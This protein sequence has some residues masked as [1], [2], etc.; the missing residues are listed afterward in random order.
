VLEGSTVSR[1][2]AY[3]ALRREASRTVTDGAGTRV[4]DVFEYGEA[5]TDPEDENLRGK[6]WRTWH[7][8]GR[9]E[10]TSYDF[11]GN[12]LSWTRRY[13]DRAGTSSDTADWTTTDDGN[14]ESDTDLWLTTAYT[15]DALNRVTSKTAPDGAVQ[16]FT[17]N[18]AGLFE[19]TTVDSV[20]FVSGVAYNA[21]GQREN[22][23]YGNGI[24]TEYTYEPETFRLATLES[25]RASD[26]KVLQDLTFTYDPVGN[27][28]EIVNAADDTVF[29]DNV[30]V[31]PDQ[32]FTYDAYYRLKTA[33]GREKV[34]RGQ[35][36]N[37]DP[38]A[39][40]LR[41]PYTAVALYEER[42]TYDA[43][44]NITEMRH[45]VN[46]ATD[47]VR[48]YTYEEDGSNDPVSNRLVDTTES[49]GT[50]EYQHDDRGNIVF[51]PHLYND[52]ATPDPSPNVEYDDRGQMVRAQIN[53]SD[54][55]LYYYDSAGQRVRKVV[56]TGAVVEDRRYVDGYE[57][58]RKTSS[59]TLTEERTTL[60][61]MDGEKRIA[62]VETKTVGTS[63]PL[64]RIRYQLGNHLGT[65]V[66]E[67]NADGDVISY[68]E[69][70]PYGSTAWWTND[71]DTEVSQKRYR[72]TGKEKDEETGL[73]YHGARYY[74][75]WLGRWTSADPSRLNDGASVYAYTRGRPVN[76]W[77]PT[78]MEGVDPEEDADEGEGDG[79]VRGTGWTAPTDDSIRPVSFTEL[80]LAPVTVAVTPLVEK[81]AETHPLFAEAMRLVGESGIMESEAVLV[82]ED[83]PLVKA[84]TAT[85]KVGAQAAVRAAEAGSARLALQE[86]GTGIDATI[87]RAAKEGVA[88]M[89]V[90]TDEGRLAFRFGK[91][92]ERFFRALA[93]VG[94]RAQ[95]RVKT[96]LGARY[97]DFLEPT[98]T[99]T[100]AHEVK[101]G[102]VKLSKVADQIA[103]DKEILS[104]GAGSLRVESC[105]WH[106]FANEAGAIGAEEAVFKALD[107]AGIKYIIHAE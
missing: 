68:E 22:I 93:D 54:Y 82:A 62:M 74:A 6:P 83:V 37:G 81:W 18:E 19:T 65:S 1:V 106:F 28:R 32:A 44:G 60:H 70:H 107:E 97:I 25:T 85:A 96:A 55:A 92:A 98:A 4:T 40:T 50:V 46:S 101:S 77:D 84:A 12:R 100:A 104:T 66:L 9:D 51:L 38:A 56:V 3:D 39:G 102:F 52:G 31:S 80:L 99:G 23:E 79:E 17:Y 53:G 2:H 49:V 88:L 26:S 20:D 10:F 58:W 86:L 27:I 89:E 14:L 105:T 59:G 15:Y 61:V 64:T 87:T 47:W 43:V 57:V 35:P 45:L 7:K 29:F 8:G 67:V 91:Q 63:A 78:G 73:Y 48:T 95:V 33:T 103:K 94:A 24:T 90:Q 16:A 72:Y 13:W 42:Y 75:P 5:S 71:G 36:Y 41:D 69:Y 30:A 11:K 76:H 21:R 34:S